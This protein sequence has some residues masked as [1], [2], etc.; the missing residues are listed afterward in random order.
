VLPGLLR[1]VFVLAGVLVLVAAIG[2]GAVLW[3]VDPGRFKPE[4]EAAAQRALGRDLVLRGRVRIGYSLPPTLVAEDIALAG[5]F[6][7]LAAA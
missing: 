7:A 6:M 2:A 1:L 4:I 5:R 3:L